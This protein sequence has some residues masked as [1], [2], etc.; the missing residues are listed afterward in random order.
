MAKGSKWRRAWRAAFGLIVAFGLYVTWFIHG[1]G[2]PGY[3]LPA[4][5]HT[6]NDVTRLNA[7]QVARELRP[8]RLE[9]ITTALRTS[10]GPVSIGGGRYSQGGQVAYPESLHVDM[11]GYNRIVAINPATREIRVQAGATWRQ[12]EQALEPYNLAIRIMQTY[13]NFTVGGS[14]SVNVHGRYIGEGAIVRSVRSLQLVLADGSVVEASPAQHPE[15]FYGAIGGYGGLG[16]ITEA[17]LSVVPNEKVEQQ[18][19]FLPVAEY[20]GYFRQAIRGNRDVVFHNADLYP[21]DFTEANAVSWVRTQKPLTDPERLLPTGQTY[22]LQPWVIDRIAGSDTGKWLRRHAIDPL[23]YSRDRVFWRSREASYDVA[24]LAPARHDDVVYGLREFFVPVARFDDFVAAMR[25]GFA[26]HH[27]N[28]INVSVR[29]AFPD[30]GTLLAWSRQEVFAFV[31]YYQQGTDVAARNQVRNWTRELDQAAI[32]LGG[33]YYLPYQVYETDAQFH[34][35]Y[36]RANEFLALKARVDPQN[37]FRN[38]LWAAHYPADAPALEAAR[39]QARQ[40]YRGEEQTLLTIPE[41]Y[42]VFN[43]REYADFLAAGRDPSDFPFRASLQ[44]Y[45][46]QYDRV[47]VLAAG[48]YP[49]NPEYL[50]MLRVIGV[51]TTVEYLLKGAYESTLGRLSGW[52]GGHDTPEDHLVAQAQRAYSN[53]I[54]DK[55]WYEFDFLPWVGRMWTEPPLL[56]PHFVRKLERRLFFTVEFTLKAGYASLIGWASHAAYEPSDDFIYAT[57][58]LPAAAPALPATVKVMARDGQAAVLAVPRWGGFTRDV[59]A[60]AR[61]GV[62]FRDIAGNARI[63]LSVIAPAGQPVT[64]ASGHKLFDSAMVS[65]PGLQRQVWIVPV[66]ELGTTLRAL[67]GD[68]RLV[69]EHLYD[70]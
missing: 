13:S 24:E 51:S 52:L 7:T 21:P 53:L 25:R 26:R 17:T 1:S 22:R 30:P 67:A 12:I 59:P 42:L 11:R 63:A 33:A 55:A 2:D 66:R 39:Q 56:G 20:A 58:T 32:D 54:Y 60:L 5:E 3:R 15:L 41:W 49:A 4:A 45:W 50:T 35:A 47:R 37:R 28:V 18:H 29:H 62:D 65:R 69:L 9:E 31:V 48:R 14:L 19:R 61:A 64:L 27:V 16:I 10:T 40:Y 57:A 70:Y 8:T 6:V 36:P 44:E 34:A 38:R 46:A 68:R 43:P 23:Y